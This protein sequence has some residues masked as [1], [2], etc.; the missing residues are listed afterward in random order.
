M[1]AQSKRWRWI[2]ID[3]LILKWEWSGFHIMSKE[4]YKCLLP[5]AFL[6]ISKPEKKVKALSLV[7]GPLSISC[8]YSSKRIVPE[9]SIRQRVEEGE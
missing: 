5:I 2:R 7:F 8:A 4:G 3:N 1:G 6:I 9:A